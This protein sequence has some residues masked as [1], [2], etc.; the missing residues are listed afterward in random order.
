MKHRGEI[1]ENAIRQSDF[2]ISII[3]KRI[4]KSRQYIYNLF[5]NP[6]IHLD[7]LFEIG[8]VIGH[9]FSR[10]IEHPMLGNVNENVQPYYSGQEVEKIK[11]ELDS[12]K[13]K[14]IDLLEK[15]TLLIAERAKDG[16]K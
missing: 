6:S 15:Y 12:L 3:A 1:L 14:Y 8:K 16:N 7:V 2:S 5:A 11:S 13:S 9:D 4:G 10:D